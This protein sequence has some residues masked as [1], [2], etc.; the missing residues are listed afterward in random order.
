[1][2]TQACMLRQ[3][4]H[5]VLLLR[6]D[7]EEAI[8]LW[9]RMVAGY[10]L[11]PFAR[12]YSLQE[13][14]STIT[15][16]TPLLEGTITG[17]E[18]Y[19]PM[20]AQ[21]P[22]FNALVEGIATL[23][24]SYSQNL[25]KVIFEQTPTERMLDLYTSLQAFTQTSTRWEPEML[26]PLLESLP[27]NSPLSVYGAGPNWLYGALSAH[28]D[29]TPFY[30]CDPRF[31]FGWTQPVAVSIS[32]EHSAEITVDSH[33]Y[34]D[35]SV[36]S[37]QFPYKHLEYFQPEPL[38][39]PPMRPDI[40]LIINGHPP[41]LVG[42]GSGAPLQG[43]WC[44]LDRSVLC[45]KGQS[46]CCIFTSRGFCSRRFHLFT[47]YHFLTKLIVL[48]HIDEEKRSSIRRKRYY[49]AKM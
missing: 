24:S 7:K 1:M 17:L 48:Y 32:T 3:C 40:G 47:S 27:L 15:T 37:I 8:Q 21:G 12:I 31:S 45:A 39:F 10:A 33:L 19:N 43:S 16:Q 2:E 35:R 13:G 14:I 22:L 42:Y 34:A 49:Q 20:S 30:Q 18:R 26:K 36:L 28:T 29:P 23:F 6:A 4:T 41:V 5:S 9:S 25:E 11:E 46:C 44:S 38:P